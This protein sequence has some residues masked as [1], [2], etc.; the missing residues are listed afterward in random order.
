MAMRRKFSKST[1]RYTV[2]G[3]A[4]F[5]PMFV[6]FELLLAGDVELNPGDAAEEITQLKL[7]SKGLRIGHWN[8]ERLTDSKL[9]QISFLLNTSKNVDILFLLETVLKPTKSDSVFNIPGY[10]MFRKDRS[11][12]KP[13]GGLIAYVADNV[14]VN[15]LWDLEDDCVESIWLSVHPHNSNRPILVGALYRPPSTNVEIDS[16]IEHNIETAYLRN[17]E[18]ILV[19]DVNVNYLDEKT[20]SKHRLIKSLIRLVWICPNMSLWQQDQRAI[21]A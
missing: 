4:T 17:R 19:G 8:V 21:H 14:K 11:G 5:N 16:K 6:S 2:N 7:P 12:R 13:G 10:E 20:Y 3:D 1:V 18:M 9:E 15:R